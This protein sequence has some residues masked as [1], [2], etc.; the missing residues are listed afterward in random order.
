MYRKSLITSSVFTD[1]LSGAVALCG[2]CA[3]G[4]GFDYRAGLNV[5]LTN[6]H[7]LQSVNVIY[8]LRKCLY[9]KKEFSQT[10]CGQ[11]TSSAFSATSCHCMS[12]VRNMLFLLVQSST[13]IQGHWSVP[14]TRRIHH[15]T[16]TLYSKL[17]F[18]L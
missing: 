18:P 4:L 16:I 10:I 7:L 15:A 14:G 17:C 3:W 6:K 13:Y 2:W 1:S 12:S 8:I 11:S 5:Y 9:K